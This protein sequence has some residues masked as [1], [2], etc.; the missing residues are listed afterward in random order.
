MTPSTSASP[1]RKEYEAGELPAPDGDDGDARQASSLRG[2]DGGSDL[3]P[4]GE[5]G[6]DHKTTDP[7]ADIADGDLELFHLRRR[8][9]TLPLIEQSKGILI[10]H[11]GIDADTA[12]NLLRQWSCDNNLKLRDISRQV[13]VAATA[14]NAPRP[15]LNRFLRDFQ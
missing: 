7:P 12:F 2:A 9:E 3:I 11:Y 10:R 8:L 1:R 6:V 14:S 4:A 15:S 13:V 5:P